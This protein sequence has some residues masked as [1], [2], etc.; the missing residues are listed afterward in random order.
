[1]TK[2][3]ALR[4]SSLSGPS[5]ALLE[6]Q[7]AI[8]DDPQLTDAMLDYAARIT[9]LYAQEPDA[10]AIL[11]DLGRFSVVATLAVAPE[12]L[13]IRATW[14]ALSQTGTASAFR[15][16]A[17]IHA[18]QTLGA[19]QPA[20]SGRPRGG[21]ERWTLT[22]K[23][24]AV[25]HRWLDAMAGPALRWHPGPVPD[26]DDGAVLVRYLAQVL[27]AGQRGQSAFAGLPRIG[28][29]IE[30]AGGHALLLALTR[31]S[32]GQA[33]VPFDFSRSAFAASC[34]VSRSHVIDL[35]DHLRQRGDLAQHNRQQLVLAPEFSAELRAWA[36]RL[37]VLALATLDGRLEDVMP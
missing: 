17:H 22:D 4:A 26:L 34:G 20:R 10:V 16:G 25:L 1:M 32:G 33:S 15:V 24:R 29:L 27:A 21:G 14:R 8:A 18:L 30:L 11:G 3:A 19:V 35:L 7:A 13:S 23:A 2:S 37:M 6:R 36:A 9:S 28:R 12:P 5:H 31:A